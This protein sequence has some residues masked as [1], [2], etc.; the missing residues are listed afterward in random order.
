MFCFIRFVLPRSSIAPHEVSVASARRRP[1]SAAADVSTLDGV[2]TLE[3]CR[4]PTPDHVRTMF[5]D[6]CASE[7]NIRKF[8]SSLLCDKAQFCVVVA[9]K[10]SDKI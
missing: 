4:G 9:S 7:E 5:G 1:A 2:A 10:G 8:A 3:G 6:R